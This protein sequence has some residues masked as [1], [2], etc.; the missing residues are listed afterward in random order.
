MSLRNHRRLER[1]HFS[2]HTAADALRVISAYV[3]NW[4]YTRPPDD[5][6]LSHWKTVSGFQPELIWIAYRDGQ[7]SAFLH[8]ELVEGKRISIHLLAM[9][10]G[11]SADAAWLVG[12]IETVAHER[13]IP[14]L[15][16]PHYASSAFYAA[17]LL[18]REPFHPHWAAE[19]TEAYVRAGFRIS[20]SGVLM[21]RGLRRPVD[22]EDAPAGYDIRPSPPREEFDAEAFGYRALYQ[23]EEV[24]RCG[25]RLYPR[26][27]TPRGVPIGQLGHVETNEAHRGRGLVR[28]LCRVCLKQL[29]DRGAGECLIAT[30]LDNAPALRAYERAGFERR[31]HINEWSKQINPS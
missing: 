31:Y 13:R 10:P 1:K 2:A 5:A 12:E 14:L 28:N 30:G 16:G 18:G 24:S 25:A 22:V 17:Y 3:S 21:I 9:V 29:R 7:P 6:L 15:K 23:G 26:L 8:G 19:G 20:Y 4:P 27:L 11:A